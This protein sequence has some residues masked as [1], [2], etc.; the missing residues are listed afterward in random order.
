MTSTP[1]GAEAEVR[2]A[3]SPPPLSARQIRMYRGAF[4]VILVSE[5][6]FFVTLFAVRFLL[7]GLDRPAGLGLLLSSLATLL[8]LAGGVTAW[9]ALG[10]VREGD[11]GAAVT[12]LGVS[13]LIGLLALALVVVEAVGAPGAGTRYGDILGATTWIHAAHI[14]TGLVFLAALW[15]SA[16]RGRFT[17][18]NHWVLEAGAR[19]WWFVSAAWLA[20]YVVFYWL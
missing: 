3:T 19:F 17:V 10:A 4:I 1:S 2:I 14:V 7:V 6:F 5:S 16:R 15:S 11:H 12:N 9:L 13:L 20:L 18:Q 8:F